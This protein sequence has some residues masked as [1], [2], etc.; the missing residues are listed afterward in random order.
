LARK[1]RVYFGDNSV[2][3]AVKDIGRKGLRTRREFVELVAAQVLDLADLETR[4]NTGRPAKWTLKLW[5]QRC[6]VLRQ[7]N[8]S[9]KFGLA[10]L[11]KRACSFGRRI[12]KS[13]H[14]LPY[15]KRLKILAEFGRWVAER[16]GV[17]PKTLERIMRRVN[18][19]E[20]LLKRLTALFYKELKEEFARQKLEPRTAT[21]RLR[22]H[23][24]R[25]SFTGE[26]KRI[27]AYL[28][29]LIPKRYRTGARRL[30]T[31]LLVLH[32]ARWIRKTSSEKG[33]D[34]RE[35]D[36]ASEIDWKQGYYY[37]KNKVFELLRMLGK[38]YEELTED[39]IQQMLEH[40]ARNERISVLES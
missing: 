5:N 15:H 28:W 38:R 32:L 10:G 19:N 16:Y 21:R 31:Y 8:K 24:K 18:E 39:E 36:W 17:A 27:A 23:I 40:W 14:K 2:F 26:D 4:R 29:E 34:W 22:R 35:I 1:R 13:K 7:L 37:A 20:R 3:K 6:F 11:V 30:W 9:K 33:I 25:V 12:L